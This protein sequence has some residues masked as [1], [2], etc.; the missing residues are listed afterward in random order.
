MTPAQL[1]HLAEQADFAAGF[2]KTTNPSVANRFTRCAAT[3]RQMAKNME[4]KDER[5]C[6]GDRPA[7]GV[8]EWGGRGARRTSSRP[9]SVWCFDG[10]GGLRYGI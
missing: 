10:S 5:P 4:R 3:A 7:G 9:L 1:A 6:G 8:N 2:F